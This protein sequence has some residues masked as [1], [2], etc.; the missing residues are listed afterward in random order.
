MGKVVLDDI[1]AGMIALSDVAGP[2]GKVLLHAGNKVQSKHLR[3]FR[4]WGVKEIDVEGVENA[5]EVPEIVFPDPNDIPAEIMM[6]VDHLF[7]YSG[8]ESEFLDHLKI[9]SANAIMKRS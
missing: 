4:M 1:E 2:K 7:K 9:L 6:I 3:I 8:N 5:P